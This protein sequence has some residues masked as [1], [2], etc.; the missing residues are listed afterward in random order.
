MS[1]SGKQ[2]TPKGGATATAQ[3]RLDDVERK[4]LLHAAAN[5]VGVPRGCYTD[6]SGKVKKAQSPRLA[7]LAGY[8]NERIPYLRAEVSP[9]YA[10]TDRKISGS[11]LRVIGEGRR[12][13]RLDVYD[14]ATGMRVFT[15]DSA[16]T[17]RTN[18][19]AAEWVVRHRFFEGSEVVVYKQFGSHPR[20]R[21][22]GKVTKVVDHEHVSVRMETDG[23]VIVFS[24]HDLLTPLGSE[25][26]QKILDAEKSGVREG[27][28]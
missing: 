12:G 13:N 23:K 20:D 10:S 21:E 15:H 28:S 26:A 1:Y 18:G 11:R 3:H 16:Q 8:I 4:L 22:R 25:K 2:T 27:T 14:R 5:R 9:S 17:Y 24:G 19:E 6:S 7:Q